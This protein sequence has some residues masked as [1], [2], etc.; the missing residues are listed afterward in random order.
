MHTSLKDWDFLSKS[1]F[2]RRAKKRSPFNMRKKK[3]CIKTVTNCCTY[4]GQ[5][6]EQ[7]LSRSWQ[8]KK[9]K[10]Y[11][12]FWDILGESSGNNC[13]FIFVYLHTWCFY[14]CSKNLTFQK[15]EHDQQC[16]LLVIAVFCLFILML[17]S[18]LVLTYKLTNLGQRLK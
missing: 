15:A 7:M 3:N 8:K 1:S 5:K 6:W 11:S 13:V 10:S 17:V 4:I 9:K 12:H 18:W 14:I 2:F 16:Q